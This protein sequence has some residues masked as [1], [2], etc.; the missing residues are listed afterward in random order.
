[1]KRNWIILAVTLPVLS[2]CGCTDGT[3]TSPPATE[4]PQ[5]TVLETR[6]I[7]TEEEIVYRISESEAKSIASD[8]IKTKLEADDLVMYYHDNSRFYVTLKDKNNNP[9]SN[10]NITILLNG[11][12]NKRTTK[13]D[14]SASLAINLNSGNYNV[15]VSYSGFCHSGS[16]DWY[17]RG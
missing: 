5:I 6:N 11:V 14:G 13:D 16:G 12:E 10:Q 9:L 4:T 2:F 15:V 1:M 8:Y 3:S 7:T 17:S